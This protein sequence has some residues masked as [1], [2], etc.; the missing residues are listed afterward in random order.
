MKR[1][2]LLI[3]S[4]N[5]NGFTL[6]EI[7]VAMAVLALIMVMLLTITVQISDM[8]R[9]TTGKIEQFRSA[10]DAFDS[11]SRRIN[12]ATLNT[13]W[14][15]DDPITPTRYVR[16]SELRFICGQTETLAGKP[17][18]PKRWAMHGIFFQAPFG[19]TET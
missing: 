15:Y 17:A 18:S 1:S 4:E 11:M 6:V 9:K 12:Q 8:W 7:L 3:C 14:D 16:Q 5:R 2:V 13:Y 19:F 10:R